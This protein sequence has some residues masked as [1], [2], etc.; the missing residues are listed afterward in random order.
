MTQ[1]GQHELILGGQRSGKSRCAE[2]RAA[3]WLAQPGH[4]A[5]LLATA[6]GG[7]DEM[8]ARINRHRQDRAERVPALAA[9]DVPRQLAPAVIEHST[10]QRLLVIDCLTLWLTNLLMPLHGESLDA[11]AWS[12]QR[13]ALG[14]A[15][16]RAPG[17]V[18]L[19]SNEIGM[20]IAPL[21]PEARRFVD[22]LGHLHQAVA[23][24]C[25]DVTLLV[26]GIELA[27]KRGA[28]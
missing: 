4:S 25:A 3:A 22:E 18:L 27:V 17:P 7:D 28:L 19:V 6:L 26:A 15:L 12:A 14:D 9:I 11:A 23:A 10:P 1:F 16:R 2:R 13:D 8:R 24:L 20:G 21:T 5:L